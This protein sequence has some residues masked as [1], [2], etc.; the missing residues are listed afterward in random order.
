M[1]LQGGGV[2]GSG[3]GSPEQQGAGTFWTRHM[4]VT[5]RRTLDR[6][7]YS[8]ATPP[9]HRLRTNPW[10]VDRHVHTVLG[11][12]SRHPRQLHVSSRVLGSGPRGSDT[13]VGAPGASDYN[14][15][16]QPLEW[17]SRSVPDGR[18]RPIH[19]PC[20]SFFKSYLRVLPA[21][22]KSNEG[23]WRC[24]PMFT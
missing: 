11:P 22:T 1:K 13:H 5:R 4:S 24:L 7:C 18:R 16:G 12:H 8:G 2:E 21:E 9:T 15:S 17:G 10:L 23:T 19:R 6:Y 3:R 20:E 14:A